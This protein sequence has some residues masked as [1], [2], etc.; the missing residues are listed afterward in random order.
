MFKMSI[1]FMN[2]FKILESKIGLIR[3]KEK[4]LA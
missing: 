2:V 1:L 4:L 3:F